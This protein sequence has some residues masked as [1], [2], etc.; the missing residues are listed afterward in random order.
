MLVA[1][2]IGNSSITMGV[3]TGTRLLGRVDIPVHPRSDASQFRRLIEAFLSE[4]KVEK[5]VAGVIISSVV[6]DLTGILNRSLRGFSGAEPV[7]VAHSLVTGL[8]LE[9]ESPEEVGTDRIS[10][11]VAAWEDFCCPVAVVDFGTATTVSVIR[12]SRFLGGAI[13]PGLRLMGEA[14]HQGT[15]RLPSVDAASE[16][17]GSFFRVAALGKNTKASMISG[18]IYGTSGAVERIIRAIEREQGCVFEVVVTGGNALRVMPYIER[19]CSVDPDL[20]LKGLRLI[21]ER[22][23]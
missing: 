6:P 17:R 2:D 11:A 13:L 19:R 12:D 20:T 10:N 9:V 23:A 15:A 4:K 5:P 21:Y 22:N 8:T 7:L 14:L 1:V 16:G 3:F 18:M